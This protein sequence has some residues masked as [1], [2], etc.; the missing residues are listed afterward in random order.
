[1]I[2]SLRLFFSSRYFCSLSFLLSLSFLIHVTNTPLSLFIQQRIQVT[3]TTTTDRQTVR[4]TNKQT[5]HAALRD[6]VHAQNGHTLFRFFFYILSTA[7]LVKIGGGSVLISLSLFSSLSLSLLQ[8]RE[9]R[10]WRRRQA[11]R[12]RSLSLSF[13]CVCVFVRLRIWRSLLSVR[14][15]EWRRRRRTKKFSLFSL[16]QA[17][18]SEPKRTKE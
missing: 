8:G 5:H 1:M 14:F 7:S 11:R 13:V 10:Q 6:M 15:W 16:R 3:R 17:D 18:R 9:V 4:Q 2:S 12:I